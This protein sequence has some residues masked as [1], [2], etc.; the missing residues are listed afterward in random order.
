M[1]SILRKKPSRYQHARIG[2]AVSNIRGRGISWRKEVAKREI[3][4]TKKGA[5]S[6]FIRIVKRENLWIMFW[7]KERAMYP[8]GEGYSEWAGPK[9][10][11]WGLFSGSGGVSKG[12]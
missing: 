1:V 9:D 3:E 11:W 8:G 2:R 7:R 10:L 12:S 6:I 5:A 4:R